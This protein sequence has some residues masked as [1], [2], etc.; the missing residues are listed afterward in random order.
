MPYA[1]TN[2]IDTFY[3]ETGQ[4]PPVVLIH[5]HS[6]NLRMWQYQ[7]PA[8]LQAGY[9]VVRY[10]VRGHGR[11]AA[12]AQGYT[13][14]NHAADLADLLTCLD[15]ESAHL[16]GLSMGGGIAL[17]F[18]LDS[19]QRVLSLGLIDSTL[20]GFTYSDEFTHQ[21]EE[22]VRVVRAEGPGPAFRHLWLA[23]PFFDGLRAYP[24]RFALLEEMVRTFPAAD[25]HR[26]AIPPGYSSAIADRLGEI[27]APAVVMVGEQDIPDFRLIADILAASLPN[28]HLSV[29]SGCGHVPPLEQ[30]DAF[31]EALI[32]FL[33]EVSAGPL[34]TDTERING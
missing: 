16:V 32:A 31:N 34:Q 5:G 14:E 3:E 27:A 24:E 1:Y 7:V 13:W 29:F 8:L 2:G 20:P 18:V 21:V 26:G 25:Y 22:L 12:P 10:D 30:P 28:A 15:V 23:H 33:R 9:R 4:G 11:S 6:L 19:P 17:Q